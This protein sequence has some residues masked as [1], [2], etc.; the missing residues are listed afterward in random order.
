MFESINTYKR[1]GIFV[2]YDAIGVM[3]EYAENLLES[4]QR[5][6]Q[7]LIVIVNGTIVNS[8]YQKLKKKS[9]EVYIRDNVG[10]DAGAYKDAVTKFLINEKLDK[11]DEIVLFNDTFYGPIHPWN[12]LFHKMERLDIDFW[13]LSKFPKGNYFDTGEAIPEHIQGYFLVCRKSLFLSADWRNFWYQLEYPRTYLEAVKNFEIFFSQY[14]WNK[15]Y[16]SKAFTDDY[17]E[18]RVDRENPTMWYFDKFIR[19]LGFPII[20][21]RVFCLLHLYE[22]GRTIEYIKNNTDYNVQ[23]IS[24]HLE[25]L[26]REDRHPLLAP[27]DHVH[28]RVFCKEHKRIFIYGHGVYGKGIATYLEYKGIKYEGFVVSEKDEN[29]EDNEGVFV[30]RNMKFDVR[31]GI[32]LAL[33]EEAFYEVYPMVKKNLTDTQQQYAN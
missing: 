25:R 31:D 18:E 17:C 22:V 8:A 29:N 6:V 23:L 1:M 12:D 14:F 32:I 2:F 10:Y 11:W 15:G 16:V 21:R 4:I 27:F 26:C 24:S 33:G 5:E 19:N 7:K 9:Y 13:G 20:K 3:D 30:Y 28:L